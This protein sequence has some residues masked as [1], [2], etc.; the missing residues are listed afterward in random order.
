MTSGVRAGALSWVL[1]HTVS[2]GSPARS[3]T[4]RKGG[5]TRGALHQG[6]L[7]VECFESS[8]ATQAHKGRG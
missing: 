3:K 2:E 7:G 4:Q 1:G 5:Q 6:P 8:C